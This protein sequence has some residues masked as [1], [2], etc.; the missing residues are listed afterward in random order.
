MAKRENT[1]H[2]V[3]I[4]IS[5]EDKKALEVF[6]EVQDSSME[7]FI[8][9]AMREKIAREKSRTPNKTTLET[10]HKTDRGE[11]LMQ[12]DDFNSLLIDIDKD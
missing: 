6:I 5:D 2:S 3:N 9:S 7:E 1:T 11:E 12:Y 4:N 10:F 8:I